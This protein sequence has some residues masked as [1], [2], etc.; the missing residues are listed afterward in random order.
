M[1]CVTATSIFRK[2]LKSGL[3]R[4][5]LEKICLVHLGYQRNGFADQLCG[6]GFGEGWG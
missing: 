2:K 6:W 5:V 4:K 1:F 3:R